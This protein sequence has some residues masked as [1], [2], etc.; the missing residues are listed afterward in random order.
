MAVCAVTDPAAAPSGPGRSA[1]FTRQ[2]CWSGCRGCPAP[3]PGSC[4]RSPCRW[5][6]PAGPPVA[7]GGPAGGGHLHGERGHDPGPGAGQPRQ[8]DQHLWRVNAADRPGPEGAAAGS[9][10]AQTAIG[11]YQGTGGT[12]VINLP[13]REPRRVPR[14]FRFRLP[15]KVA[16]FTARQEQ[17]AALDRRWP[18]RGLTAP[19][20]QVL[21]GLP[22]VGKTQLAAAYVE[23]H[24]E[25]YDLVAWVRAA[26]PL[27]DLADLADQLRLTELE[28]TV[29]QRAERTVLALAAWDS[30]WLLMLDNVEDPAVLQQWCPAAGPGRILVTT[31]HRELA[32]DYGQELWLPVFDLTEATTYLLDRSGHGDEQRA[33]AEAV[34]TALGRLPLA[35][36]HAGAYCAVERGTSF[37]EYLGLLAAL[38]AAELFDRSPEAFYT[39]TVATT[40]ATSIAAATRRAPLAADVLNLA[41]VLDPDAIPLELFTVLAGADTPSQAATRHRLNRAVAELGAFSLVD[42]ADGQLAVHRLLQKV[43]RDELA[44]AA[45][46]RPIGQAVTAVAAALPAD[47]AAPSSWLVCRRLV[48]HAQALAQLP[49]SA[50]AD[51]RELVVGLFNRVVVYQLH[52]GDQTALATLAPRAADL[53][54]ALLGPEHPDTLTARANLA[55]SYGSAGRTT[56]AI[57]IQ[58]QVAA[59]TERLLGP[60]HPA[61]LTIRSNLASSYWSAGRTTEAIGIQEQVAADRERLLGPEHPATLTARA[62]LASSYYAAGR[63]TEAI[64]LLEQVAA[65]TERLLGPE[66]PDTLTARSNLAGSYGS[67]GRTTEAIG[68]QEQV[69]ADTE[70]LLGPEHPATLT[71]RANLATSYRA[72]GR[73]T[74][75]IGIEEQVAAD[76][77]RLLGPEHPA[78]LTARANLAGS[79]HAAGRTTAVS[80]T[81]LR[82]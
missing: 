56:E 3:G 29:E 75:A 11:V 47:V 76:T 74:E 36:A 60:E 58:E 66:H 59:D 26:N 72:A 4:P 53:A 37:T 62:N 73:T 6:P 24:V 69:A 51:C 12:Q 42:V 57:G 5:P 48:T 71:A 19:P 55:R 2:R 22:G 40:W 23:A 14:L 1:A 9:V 20:V 50:L 21:T 64:G 65:D 8:P 31:R 38:P 39:E 45:N 28:D 79:Y 44:R 17:L 30:P 70:R 41:A 25:G 27:A 49:E 33:A 16:T 52:A 68:I 35:L 32:P 81:H 82:A 13:G 18:A 77:E 10:T 54:S 61:T 80:Y 78:T 43:V 67:A 46:T 63:T 34:A 7:P 15:R